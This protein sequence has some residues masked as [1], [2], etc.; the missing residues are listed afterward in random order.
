MKTYWKTFI[1]IIAMC[2]VLLTAEDSLVEKPDPVAAGMSAERLAQMTSRMKQFVDE[3]KVAGMV[4]LVARRGK[5]ANLE[6]LGY[7]DLGSKTA[8]K[9]DT[10][11]RVMSVTKPVTCAGVMVLVDEG[12]LSLLDPVEKF[13]PEFRGIRVNPC[14]TRNGFD[15]QLV[16]AQRPFTVLDLMTHTSGLGEAGRG[17]AT[18]QSRAEYIA[19]GAQRMNLIFQ[20]GTTWNYSNFGIGVLGRIIEVASGQSF[21]DFMKDRLFSP[22]GMKDTFFHI[23]ADK[24]SRVATVYTM[25]NGKLTPLD[26]SRLLSG[27]ISSPDSGLLSTAGDLARFLEMMLNKGTLNGKRVLS[28]A[29]VETMTA[30]HTGTLQAGYTP[31]TAQGFGFEVVREPLGMFRYASMGTFEKA[32]VYRTYVWGDPAKDLLGVILMARNTG[33]Y[34]ADMAD[35]VNVF[36]AMAAASIAE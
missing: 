4:T 31:G 5:V 26:R 11:F 7:Q 30:P 14:G 9:T 6:A 2:P 20:P 28:A 21:D 16:P 18:P 3:G 12:R 34:Q 29:A 24:A 10:I 33:G 36:M 35:E 32:G 27:G 19:E 13:I 15:C 22:L 8:M 25:E 23:P 17:S 1:L